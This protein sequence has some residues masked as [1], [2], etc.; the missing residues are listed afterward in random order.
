[1]AREADGQGRKVG[2][3]RE[4]QHISNTAARSHD[5]DLNSGL[6]QG[7]QI[8]FWNAMVGYDLVEGGNWRNQ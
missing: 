4:V 8:R 1:M 2:L 5:C 3:S 6:P 7:V